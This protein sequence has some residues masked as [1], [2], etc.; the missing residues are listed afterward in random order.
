MPMRKKYWMGTVPGVDDFGLPIG[1]EFVDGKTK[2]GP[3][4][5]MAPQSYEK[6]GV[7]LGLG[8]GQWYAKQSDGQWLKIEG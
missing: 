4:G 1:D 3:W 6:H 8:R 2:S 7:G 5:F